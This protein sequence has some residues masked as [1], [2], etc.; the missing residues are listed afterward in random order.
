MLETTKKLPPKANL[1][2]LKIQARDLYREVQQGSPEAVKRFKASLPKHSLSSQDEIVNAKS[3]RQDA[4]MVVA[5]EYGF[6]TWAGIKEYVE[7]QEKQ[8]N[9][10]DKMDV[11]YLQKVQYR[12]DSNLN[13]RIEIHSRFTPPEYNMWQ[14]L[15]NYFD[16][17]SGNKVLDAGCGN[18]RFWGSVWANIPPNVSLTLLDTS[19]G[20]LEIANNNLKDTSLNFDTVKGCLGA[21][22]FADASFDVVSCQY[23]MHL[24]ENVQSAVRDL[25]RVLKPAGYAVITC[26]EKRN[27]GRIGQVADLVYPKLRMEEYFVSLS[28]ADQVVE[29]A[30]LVFSDVVVEDYDCTMKVD[31]LDMLLG[32]A[33]SSARLQTLD[34]PA[35]FWED[36]ERLVQDE[37]D[38]KGYFSIR[39]HAKILKCFK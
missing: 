15:W 14:I 18:G 8:R 20:L 7:L 26:I 19:P 17:K 32:Y 3:I 16:L 5:R 38:E 34:L 10:I 22:E 11:E 9:R 24:V 37:I 1:R 23:V 4:L 27:M 12:D 28:V 29:E 21:L 39:K 31:D 33:R 30:K 35:N 6:K 2:H 25:H 36:F 13:A